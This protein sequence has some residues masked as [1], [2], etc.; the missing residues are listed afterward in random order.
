MSDA[1]TVNCR[2][3][4]T[5]DRQVELVFIGD[6]VRMDKEKIK[7]EIEDALLTQDELREFVTKL[8]SDGE[9][10]TKSTKETNPF[11]TV[12]RCVVIWNS[13]IFTPLR[14]ISFTLALTSLVA[15][16]HVYVVVVSA[17]VYMEVS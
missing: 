12:P 3:P 11:H 8:S 5:Q 9:K 2:H 15:L 4:I 16:Y 13:N 10:D 14:Y 1:C 17:Y 7:K 6:S